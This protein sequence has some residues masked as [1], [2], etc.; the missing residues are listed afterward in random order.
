MGAIG[1]GSREGN[2]ITLRHAREGWIKNTLP[3]QRRGV[4]VERNP[5]SACIPRRK[6]L[7]ASTLD[8]EAFSDELFS[9]PIVG[10]N[11]SNHTC[12]KGGQMCND[13]VCA[14]QGM[15]N[16][17]SRLTK[18][19]KSSGALTP[20]QIFMIRVSFLSAARDL[21]QLARGIHVSGEEELTPSKNSGTL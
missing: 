7:N 13:P 12:T 8:L 2:A 19:L 14:I 11:S 21:E 6:G 9:Y 20:Q 4:K 5:Y 1:K 10:A 3:G 15:V 17:A 16:D 18:V